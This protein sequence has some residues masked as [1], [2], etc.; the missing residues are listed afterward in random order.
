MNYKDKYLKYKTKYL[1]LKNLIGGSK[2][3]PALY[4]DIKNDILWGDDENILTNIDD[5]KK[6]LWDHDQYESDSSILVSH[7]FDV[8]VRKNGISEEEFFDRLSK[9]RIGEIVLKRIK[10]S[11]N[12]DNEK[13]PDDIL[14]KYILKVANSETLTTILYHLLVSFHQALIY[15]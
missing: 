14:E 8:L 10:K 6:Q 9:T 4:E 2:L 7:A 15:L 3:Y 1:R 12:I 11:N 5:I 13:I